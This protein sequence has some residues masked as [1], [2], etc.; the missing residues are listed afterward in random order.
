MRM[1]VGIL[2]FHRA[3]NYGAAL[4][5]YAL[6]R[7]CE[8]LGFNTSIID[9][10]P[11]YIDDQYCYFKLSNN[12][13]TNLLRLYNL[14]G[15]IEKKK[16]FN[17]F[18]KE[19]MVLTPFHTSEEYDCLLYGSD[20]IWNPNI[21]HGFDKVYFGQHE[22]KASR[23]VAYAASIGKSSFSEQ[24]L[25]EFSDAVSHMD[26]ISVREE[27]ACNV[28][29]QYIDKKIETVID[30]TLLWDA[31]EWSEIAIRP[32]IDK[33]YILVYEVGKIVETMQI[34]EE[35]SARTGYPIVE[36]AYNKTKLNSNHQI[37]TNVGP[38]EFVGLLCD[39]SYVVT[40]SFHGTAFSIIN[41]KNFYTVVHRAYGS[42]MVDLLKKLGM[43]DRLVEELPEGI[44][45]IDYN[46]VDEKLKIEKEKAMNFIRKSVIGERMI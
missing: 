45:S 11:A 23:N 33:Q 22:I 41:Q 34:A 26:V 10:A 20:Q 37:L 6:M 4:Q 30:P 15:N 8:K 3:H 29:R 28:I 31:Q 44:Q 25:R 1:R 24:E 12:L 21:K 36:I 19:Y 7:A 32:M 18:Q 38:R 9:Y 35:L 39:A 46:V 13:K 27:T 5:A 17:A 43:Q 2:T 16:K 14:K 40:S 42:R